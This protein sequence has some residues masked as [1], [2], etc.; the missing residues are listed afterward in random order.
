MILCA[1]RTSRSRELRKQRRSR[2][3]EDYVIIK[4]GRRIFRGMHEVRKGLCFF[5]LDCDFGK[6]I[7]WGGKLLL[8]MN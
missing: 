3:E 6:L 5:F 8:Y 4:H 2:S 7:G 1:R